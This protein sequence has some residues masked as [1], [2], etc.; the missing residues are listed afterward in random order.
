MNGAVLAQENAALKA[1]LSDLEAALADAQEAQRRLESMLSQLRRE[2]F[3]AKSEKLAPDQFNLPLEDVELA[4]GVLQAA[5]DKAKAALKGK[6]GEDECPRNRNRGHLPMHLPRVERLLVHCWSHVRRRF[7]KLMRNQGS[8]IAEEAVRQIALLYGVESTVR[9]MAPGVRLAARRELSAPVVAAL[10]TWF[11]AQL[12]RLPKGSQIATD[13]RYALGLWSGLT[14]FLDDGRLELDTNPVE[15]QIR[16]LAL[17]RKNAL[18]AGHEVG[19]A[20]WALLASIVAT[21]KMSDVNPV[22][23]IAETLRAILDGHPRSRIE[24]LMPWHFPK[25]SSLAA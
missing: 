6:A 9:G 19:A 20:N 18:F 5:Q 22:A 15:N 17:T 8:P 14:R 3:G 21:C 4:Q 7:V 2:K 1:R 24:E 11:E 10:K 16:P 12:S 13:I 25:A 23:Y